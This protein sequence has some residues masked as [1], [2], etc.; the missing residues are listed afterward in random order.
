MG[1]VSTMIVAGAGGRGRPAMR[2][3]DAV[4]YDMV[5]GDWV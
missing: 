1:R 4:E 2:W 5:E 3:K